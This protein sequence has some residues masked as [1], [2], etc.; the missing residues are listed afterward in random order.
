MYLNAWMKNIKSKVDLKYVY[1]PKAPQFVAII[2]TSHSYIWILDLLYLILFTFYF[3]MD[4]PGTLYVEQAIPIL[5]DPT[6]SA[7]QILRMLTCYTMTDF[8]ASFIWKQSYLSF[9]FKHLSPSLISVSPEL[10]W[11]N[12]ICFVNGNSH[13]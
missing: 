9:C 2:K 1:K 5:S 4:T 13:F 6:A 7:S 11:M 12:F 3:E 8:W 10:Y